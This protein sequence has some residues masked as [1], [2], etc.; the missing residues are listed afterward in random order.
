MGK[1]KFSEEQRICA[2]T[3]LQNNDYDYNKTARAVGCSAE[4]LRKWR[5][6]YDSIL[7]SSS[8]VDLYRDK[9]EQ[10]LM[11]KKIDFIGKH[12]EDLD[13]LTGKALKRALKMI[14]G[15]DLKDVINTLKVISDIYKSI[16]VSDEDKQTGDN[17]NIIAQV[18][19]QIQPK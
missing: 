19:N 16:G 15:A 8:K 2:L 18:I 14:N 10:K 4:C 5:W 11:T 9:V 12:F 13:N 17:V 3:L 1:I 7:T 6:K